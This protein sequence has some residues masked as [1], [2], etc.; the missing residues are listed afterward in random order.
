M[1]LRRIREAF[2]QWMSFQGSLH[3]AALDSRAAAMNQPHLAKSRLMRGSDVLLDHR[4]D[5]AR[6]EWVQ[7]ERAFN[8]DVMDHW[9]S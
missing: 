4:L 8:R 1:C 7:V 6:A 2:H 3:D 9:R 5:V